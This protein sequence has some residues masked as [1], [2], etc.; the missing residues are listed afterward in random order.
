MRQRKKIAAGKVFLAV[1]MLFIFFP[2]I[3][4]A[5]YQYNNRLFLHE[6]EILWNQ[7]QLNEI[8]FR[9]GS[10]TNRASMAVDIIRSK[11]YIGVRCDS[12]TKIL[13]EKTGD[14]YHSDSNATYNL[15]EE[16]SASW[17][18][19]FVCGENGSIE[20]VNIR[21]SCCSTSQKLLH[22]GLEAIEPLIRLL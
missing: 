19:T 21:K 13:G 10:P 22:W 11:K 9:S 12:I 17:I 2:A 16:Q 4:L 5:Y 18:L 3:F 14:Y 1:A 20:K 15:S 8:E 6:A 7:K